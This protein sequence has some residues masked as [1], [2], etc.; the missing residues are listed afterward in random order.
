MTHRKIDSASRT[1]LLRA[2]QVSNRNAILDA[3]PTVVNT[4]FLRR[5]RLSY[6]IATTQ[7]HAVMEIVRSSTS[8]IASDLM[9]LSAGLSHDSACRITR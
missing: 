3:N 9:G 7:S 4:R 6:V 2:R 8:R 5:L 1:V